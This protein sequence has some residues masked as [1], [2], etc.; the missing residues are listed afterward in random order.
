MLQ[1]GYRVVGLDVKPAQ[2]EQSDDVLSR[3][4]GEYKM[5][6][7]DV[8]EEDQVRAAIDEAQTFLGGTISSLVNNAGIADS[9]MSEE[10]SQRL[11][12]YKKF[13]SVNLTGGL[14]HNSDCNDGSLNPCPCQG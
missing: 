1:A 7:T 9:T 13:L 2:D 11:A 3:F 5:L 10:P 8:S 12:A 4:K 14:H 6:E